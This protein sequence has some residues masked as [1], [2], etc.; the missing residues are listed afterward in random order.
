MAILCPIQPHKWL[1]IA[2]SIGNVNKLERTHMYTCRYNYRCT[3]DRH[4]LGKTACT[5]MLRSGSAIQIMREKENAARRDEGRPEWD[6]GVLLRAL[7]TGTRLFSPFFLFSSP[8]VY[9]YMLLQQQ[10]QCPNFQCYGV[11][12]YIGIYA[13]TLTT[14]R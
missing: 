4:K 14:W 7:D 11:Y 3:A 13:D 6:D 2:I 10:R 12:V 9:R 5:A 1:S 8:C